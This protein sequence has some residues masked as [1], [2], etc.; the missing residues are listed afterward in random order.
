MPR[1]QE[2]CL[3]GAEDCRRCHPEWN[4]KRKKIDEDSH[5]DWQDWKDDT[6]SRLF[7]VRDPREVKE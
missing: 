4:P 5:P 1:D 7:Y 6:P 2:P 3:C